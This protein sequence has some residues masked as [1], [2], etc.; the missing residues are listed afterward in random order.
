[1]KA[2]K[3][4]RQRIDVSIVTQNTILSGVYKKIKKQLQ[5]VQL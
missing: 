4:K 2:N 5:K 3:E 1:M